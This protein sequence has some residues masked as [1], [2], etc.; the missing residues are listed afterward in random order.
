[1]FG[2]TSGSGASALIPIAILVGVLILRNSRARRLRIETLWIFPVIY[3]GVLVTYLAAAPPPI[4]PVSISILV[5]AFLI[6]A[7]IGWQRGRFTEI[8]IHP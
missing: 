5:V 4:T 7:A 3:I 8:R 6:G 1:M 2:S